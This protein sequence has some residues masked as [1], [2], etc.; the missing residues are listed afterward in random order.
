MSQ[1]GFASHTSPKGEG[2]SHRSLQLKGRAE[3]IFENL[4]VGSTV[5]ELHE[6]LMA[7]PAHRA[8]VLDSEVTHVGVGLSV[9]GHLI[10][11]VEVFL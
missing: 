8:A 5:E 4:A 7:S 9:K 3:R 10:F 11:G 2:L 1:Y 6:Q